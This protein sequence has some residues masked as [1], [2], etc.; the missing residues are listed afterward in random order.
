MPYSWEEEILQRA[1]F[2]LPKIA[3][4]FSWGLSQFSPSLFHLSPPLFGDRV[5]I[6]K[7]TAK[8]RVSFRL[9]KV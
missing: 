2:L 1:F 8:K 3:S 6:Q 9:K 4:F 7:K 5:E